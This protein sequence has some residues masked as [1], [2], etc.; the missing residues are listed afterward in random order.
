MRSKQD[1]LKQIYKAYALDPAF[2]RLRSHGPTKRVVPGR[3]SMD[4]LLVFVGEAPG[5][6][7]ATTR[8]PFMGPAGKVLNGLLASVGL[9]RADIFIT[10]VVKYRPTI[11]QVSIRNRTPT[12]RE[13]EDSKPYLLRELA[14]FEGVPVV[15]LGNTPLRALT[16][17][18]RGI[19]GVK[20]RISDWHGQGWY[21]AY[22]MYCALYHPAVAVYEPAMMDTLL[23]D[24]DCIRTLVG[25]RRP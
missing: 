9:T 15:V 1:T 19:H 2:D 14:V 24:M 4:P 7:E 22:R 16:A 10:N 11:G 17:D 18:P 21:D 6:S 25:P 13:I 12:P 23:D 5:R 3:G 8:K 20:P